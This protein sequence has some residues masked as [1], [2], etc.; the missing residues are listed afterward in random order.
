MKKA[1]PIFALLAAGIFFIGLIYSDPFG[2]KTAGSFSNDIKNPVITQTN[3][4]VKFVDSLNGTNDTI[5]LRNRGWK[6]KRGPLSG[7]AGT[8]PNWF[9]GNSTVFNAFEGPPTGYVAANFNNVTGSNTIDLWLIS[10]NV[11]GNAGD[12]LSFYSRSPDASTY[13][14]SIR[15]YWASNGDTVP[16]SGSFVELGKFKVSTAG[17]VESRYVLPSAGASGRFA[18]NYRVAN[19][20]P[21]GVNS[22]F[23]GVDFIRLLGP[24]PAANTTLLLVHDSTVVTTQAERKKDRDSMR[25]HLGSVI[26]GGFDLVTFD[27]SSALPVLTGY[28]RII[29]QETAFD[30]QP[31][32]YLGLTARNN[33]TAWLN[34]GTP[35]NRKTLI[36]IGGDLAYNYARTGSPALDPVF[37]GTT[38]GFTYKLDNAYPSPGTVIGLAVDNGNTRNITTPGANYYPDGAGFSNGSFGLYRYG[39]HTAADTLAGIMRLTANYEVRSLFSDPRYYS[40]TGGW[41]PVLAAMLGNLV[42]I[43]PVNNQVPQVYSLSQNYPNPFNPVTNIKF[44]IPVSGNVK[45]VLFDILGRAVKTLVNDV[46]PAGNYV[47]DFN[48]SELSS[49]AY[50]YRLE[51]GSFVETKKMLLVK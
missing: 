48:A 13:P 6:P 32:R 4:I 39:N 41:R 40:G 8:S 18:I 45:L 12:T 11:N 30:S 5:A 20:G 27:S 24:A 43:N 19:G 50:F 1:F 25:T 47:V 38:C 26:G 16:G 49:G 42:G 51:S 31:A 17:W 21:S 9:Q 7:P 3:A 29:I 33:L 37:S 44:S 22:D 46:K 35:G 34:S 10:P 28:S 14:D 36:L 15:V 2:T 23:I